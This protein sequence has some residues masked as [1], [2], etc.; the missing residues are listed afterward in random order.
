MY[1]NSTRKS[2]K[3]LHFT[4][5]E[6]NRLMLFKKIICAYTLNH[7]NSINITAHLLNF[8]SRGTYSSHLVLKV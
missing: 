4:F 3:T 7:T 6:I 2:K 1:K 5:T 8:K